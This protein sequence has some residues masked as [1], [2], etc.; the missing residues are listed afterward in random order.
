MTEPLDLDVVE[1]SAKEFYPT[2]PST[3]IIL[4]LITELREARERIAYME[5][6]ADASYWLLYCPV[7]NLSRADYNQII[8]AK[9]THWAG[10]GRKEI[11]R[12]N[13]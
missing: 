5:E 12:S 13:N 3:G 4:N 1:S 6:D 8:R 10:E 7:C 2:H 11:K 9:C